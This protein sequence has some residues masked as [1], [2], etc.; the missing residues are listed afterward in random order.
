MCWEEYECGGMS[1]ISVVGGKCRVLTHE[2]VMVLRR[3]RAVLVQQP[4]DVVVHALLRH[5]A[6][7]PVHVVRDLAVGER[8]QQRPARAERALA[9]AQEQRRLVLDIQN[10]H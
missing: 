10:F 2:M 5:V 8:V 4:D 7:Q 6:R 9:S 3:A 1:M